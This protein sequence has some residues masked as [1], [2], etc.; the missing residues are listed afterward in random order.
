MP[1]LLGMNKPMVELS[2]ATNGT[3]AELTTGTNEAGTQKSE[4]KLS[5][6]TNEAEPSHNSTAIVKRSLESEESGAN[7]KRSK[8][9]SASRKAGKRL[10]RARKRKK[11]RANEF[12]TVISDQSRLVG[13]TISSKKVLQ[14]DLFP[15][16][17]KEIAI[18]RENKSKEAK[19]D[20]SDK[21]TQKTANLHPVPRAPTEEEQADAAKQVKDWF[22]PNNRGC[23]R[24]TT[25]Y[26]T[27]TV[28]L[29]ELLKFE[30]LDQKQRNDLD[31]LCAFFHSCR[32]FMISPTASGT[33]SCDDITSAIGWSKDITRLEI[34]DRYRNEKAIE[35]NQDLYSKFMEDSEKAGSI[36]WDTFYTFGNVAAD[37]TRQHMK[38]LAESGLGS[39]LAF[40]SNEFF[41]DHQPDEDRESDP[42]LSFAIVIPTFDSTGK[43]ASE[44][45]GHRVD[46][47]EFVFPDIKQAIQFPS[48]NICVM[49]FRAQQHA[50]GT[51]PATEFED[52]TKLMI[53][54]QPPNLQDNRTRKNNPHET[55]DEQN[56]TLEN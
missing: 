56:S 17:S 26:S 15:E 42:P 22:R 18:E 11:D 39:S 52:S 14:F 37:K 19:H 34:L 2:D 43:I 25:Q 6:I 13:I 48:D 49:I 10:C 46:N 51:L 55:R 38:K 12:E 54:I 36:L 24:L 28:C 44:S 9:V 35:T 30:S 31:F 33:L 1:S 53:C 7:P 5:D 50:H 20:H 45:E 21:D 27:E 8:T 16:I 4:T 47:G 23:T 32:Q 29:V 3:G 40:P 41:N